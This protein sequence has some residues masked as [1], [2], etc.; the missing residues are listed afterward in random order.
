[1][2]EA[3]QLAIAQIARYEGLWKRLTVRQRRL[4]GSALADVERELGAARP[5]FW[6]A[7]RSASLM[8]QLAPA[9][10]D[11]SSRQLALLQRALPSIA[12]QAQLDAA[13]WF[14]AL[15]TE[16]LGA[17][18]PLRWSSLEWLEGYSRPLLQSRLRIYRTSFARYG[19]ETVS[20]IEDEV[21]KVALLGLSWDDAREPVRK[22]IGE[23]VVGKQWMVDRIV[24]TEVATVYSS[25]TMAALIE[26]DHPEERMMKKLVAMFDKV[27]G[28]D[29]RL[30]HGQTR[31]VTELF[32]DVVSR[33][34]FDAPPNRP[35]DREIV[36]GWRSSWGAARGFDR[37]TREESPGVTAG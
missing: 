21:A 9:I 19:A 6:T 2:A 25:T 32:E 5:G 7:A 27:T 14:T 13:T 10:R 26:E 18:E 30:L 15:D 17:A 8:T 4:I 37:Q 1:V 3:A 36:V 23:A 31:L 35:H 20:A 28:L 11:L 33:K 24:R 29:S 34:K 22:I 12:R 16:F